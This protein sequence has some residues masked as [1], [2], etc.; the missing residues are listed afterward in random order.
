MDFCWPLIHV[1]IGNCLESWSSIPHCSSKYYREHSS[2][3]SKLPSYALKVPIDCLRL[4]ELL[5]VFLLL[6]RQNFPSGR[7]GLV[8]PLNLAEANNRARNPL[9]DPCQSD[10][11][12]L[13]FVVSLLPSPTAVRR[14]I[15]KSGKTS[16][17]GHSCLSAIST[18]R[19]MIVKSGSTVP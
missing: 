16:L 6:L 12:D 15:F 3:K 7:D 18:A 8:K 17:T 14:E 2:Q 19:L 11:R 5:E 10:M 13:A 1:W 4:V 9:V